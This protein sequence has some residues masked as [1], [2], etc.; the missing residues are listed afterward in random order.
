[1]LHVAHRYLLLGAPKVCFPLNAAAHPFWQCQSS[2]LSRTGLK[3][4]RN[5][6]GR[7]GWGDGSGGRH[8]WIAVSTGA[9]GGMMAV[10]VHGL[11]KWRS[12]HPEVPPSFPSELVASSEHLDQLRQAFETQSRI[13]W[14]AFLLGFMAPGW[15]QIQDAHF[16]SRKS[17]RS[18]SILISLLVG[19]LW[20]VTRDLCEARNFHRQLGL[21]D[22][23]LSLLTELLARITR[24][25]RA[26][27]RGL[28]L[29]YAFLF[30]QNLTTILDKPLRNKLAWLEA[31]SGARTRLCRGGPS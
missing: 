5:C 22:A 16:T 18:G 31:V 11:Q 6:S 4:R 3:R 26:G 14:R 21:L 7:G 24:Q 23:H 28:P 20:D 8:G 2:V 29:R 19:K 25:Y 15:A 10:M 1:M 12:G 13:G 27:P 30:K 9:G 17:R